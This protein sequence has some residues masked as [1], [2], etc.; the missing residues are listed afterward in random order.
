MSNMLHCKLSE[1]ECVGC[2]ECEGDMY[3]PS[4]S[5]CFKC[6]KTAPCVLSTEEG[7]L[8]WECE[9]EYMNWVDQYAHVGAYHAFKLQKELDSMECPF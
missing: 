1:G 6:G 7:A 3:D 9:Q 4:I 2:G 8:C 5:I